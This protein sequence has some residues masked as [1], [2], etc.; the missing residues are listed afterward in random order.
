[1]SLEENLSLKPGT[2][3]AYSPLIDMVPSDPSTIMTAMI[4][5]RRITKHTRQSMRVFTADQ[6]LYRE[7]VNVVWVYPELSDEFV[8]R[9]GGM[10]TLMSFVGSV[11]ALMGNSGLEEVLKAA[12]GGVTRKLT[13][14]NFPQNTRAF[15]MVA[16]EM[17]QPIIPRAESHED[18][19][20]ILE[21][22]AT[23]SRTAKVWVENLI[24]HVLIMMIYVQAEREAELSLHLWA[25]QQMIPYFFAAGH[26]NYARYGLYYMRSMER[27]P[28]NVLKR[29][30][31]G[32]H[33]MRHNHG[34]C[35]GIWSDMFIETTFMRYGKGPRDLVGVTL[36]PSTIQRWTLSLHTTSRVESDID[37]MRHQQGTRE[38]T[39]H[40]EEMPGRMASDAKDKGNMQLEMCIDP[41][42]SDNHPD[43]IVNIVT[44]RIAPNAV[45]IDNTVAMGKEQMKQFETGWPKTF[46]EP[47]SNKVVTMSVTKKCKTYQAGISG[48]L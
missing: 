44:G 13:G 22:E 29:F 39:T 1:M 34:V 40:N 26:V 20:S 42:N 28:E 32:E 30:L 45:N 19:V 7:A 12:F 37:E 11:G 48:L 21:K 5:S 41:L 18:L 33:V 16:E 9:L 35:N 14:K 31:N 24:I 36:K 10:H 6:Q 25:M 3:V 47:L 15:R 2:S 46:Y 38:A 8:L 4:E 27:L 43:G 23:K 17:L